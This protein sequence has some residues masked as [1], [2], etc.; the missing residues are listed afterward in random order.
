MPPQGGH[1][2]PHALAGFFGGV[3]ARASPLGQPGR[4]I[5]GLTTAEP[6]ASRAANDT[7]QTG[8]GACQHALARAGRGLARVQRMRRE[9]RCSRWV[10]VDWPEVKE[11]RWCA[12]AGRPA[13]VP[14]AQRGPPRRFLAPRMV[15]K[16][17][18]GA[19]RSGGVVVAVVGYSQVGRSPS[20]LMWCTTAMKV[21]CQSHSDWS[22]LPGAGLS[23]GVVAVMGYS[24]VH[25][26]ISKELDMVYC[27]TAMKV[28]FQSHSRWSVD[29]TRLE[30]TGATQCWQWRKERGRALHPSATGGDHSL[31]TVWLRDTPLESIL[32]TSGH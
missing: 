15:L 3:A 26:A 9:S 27:T 2:H 8:V 6:A 18:S 16:G 1:A 19:G 25:R 12:P 13:S 17:L 21:D 22:G 4:K 29:W 7:R 31:G 23:G 28:N 10:A 5:V 11:F 14:L 20:S 30:L 32:A 24:R